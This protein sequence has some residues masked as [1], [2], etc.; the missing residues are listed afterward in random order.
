MIVSN[1]IRIYV[2]LLIATLSVFFT[3]GCRYGSH[4]DENEARVRLINAVPD[5]GGLDVS[6]DGKRVWKRSQFRSSTGYQGISAGTYPIQLDS[7]D[8]GATLLV[9][10]LAFQKG[11]TYTVL[12]LGAA[13]SGK[14]PAAVQ[15]FEDVPKTAGKS[16]KALV[17]L[18]NAAPG[19]EPVD[20]VV[21]NIVGLKSVSYGRHSAALSLDGGTYDLKVV[22]A[23]TPDTL[24]GPVS[25]KLESGRS[26]TLVAMGS[27]SNQT[28]TLESYP[29]AR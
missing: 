4:S 17:R 9:G 1:P 24:I 6:V 11:R 25:L 10:S 26:Y 20:L 2:L 22:A 3:S 27:A 29:D 23:D 18:V 15:V 8:F 14:R 21:N 19:L 13:R 28:L 7:S 5:A 12:A 16:E